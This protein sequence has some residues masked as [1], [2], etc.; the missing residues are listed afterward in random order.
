M[1]YPAFVDIGGPESDDSEFGD[2]NSSTDDSI[3][4]GW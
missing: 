1:S 2:T 3:L 4:A